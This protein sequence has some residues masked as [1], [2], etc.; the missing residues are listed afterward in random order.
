MEIMVGKAIP[1]MMIGAIQATNVL[2]VAQLWFQI[3]FAGSF[4]TLYAGLVLF[5]LAAVGLGIFVS[6][7]AATMQQAMLYGF[8][9][10]MPFT[11][12]S[13][14][15]TPISNMPQILQDATLV[16]PLRYAITITQRVYLE[17]VGI[18]LLIPY[19]WPMVI[20]AAVTLTAATWM[21]RNRLE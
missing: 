16:N 6:S 13:G 7:I 14:M 12:L 21:F 20:I 5:L 11:L 9:M 8:M 15:S 4:F 2:L 19:L 18:D 3:P 10:I 1:A 17:G